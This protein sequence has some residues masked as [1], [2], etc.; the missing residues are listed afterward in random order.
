MAWR[1]LDVKA[2]TGGIYLNITYENV[3]RVTYV[4][5]VEMGLKE[6]KLLITNKAAQ[7]LLNAVTVG[8]GG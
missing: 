7:T 3:N 5:S 6:K 1:F 8:K 2:W 4:L